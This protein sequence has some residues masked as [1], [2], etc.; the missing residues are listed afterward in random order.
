MSTR[1]MAPTEIPFS[2]LLFDQG[3]VTQAVID[4]PY[5]GS[6]KAD[7]PYVIT[8]IPNDPRNP[9]LLSDSF[10]W[11][12][13]VLVS[14]AALAAALVSSAYSACLVEIIEYF[15]F[16]REVSYVG[17]SL[18]VL[19]FAL[20]PLV[21][22]PL[23]EIYGRRWIYV[24]SMASFT[25]FTAGTAG[26]TNTE[27]LLILR[28][29]AGSMGS[30]GMALPGGVIADIFPATTR[31]LAMGIYATSPFLGPTLGPIIGGFIS[32]SIGW[33]WVEGV[34]AIFT[35]VLVTGIIFLLPETYAPV[36]LQAR[37]QRLEQ[38]TGNSYRSI[39]NSKKPLYKTLGT[40]LS[41]PWLFLF[42]EPI[43]FLLCLYVAIIYGIL[44]LQ[45]AA[46]PIVFQQVRGWSEGI[47]GLS[48]LG[49]LVGILAATAY[50]FPV[51]FQYKR[52]TLA[53]PT[54]R[55]PP[56][57][58]LQSAFVGAIALPIGLF[59][60]AWTNSPSIHWISSIAAGVP[61]GFGMPLVFLP[62]S[63][64]LV[65]TYTIY[66]ASVGAA[67]T[68]LRSTFGAVFPLFTG[69]MFETLGIHWGASV[70]AFLALACAPIPFLF[71]WFGERIRS[72]SKRASEAEEFMQC[73]LGAQQQKKEQKKESG[74]ESV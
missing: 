69:Y 7:D 56:E 50:M 32:E 22:A 16:S 23:S 45:F 33:R 70:P 12:L 38:I 52:K 35:A 65:D 15:H 60:F 3:A 25:A 64:Y 13:T 39:S 48:F 59:W 36:L 4:H 61:F 21:W 41:R 40:A 11:F 53:S 27:S 8:W 31:G 55:L 26:A 58:R 2:G 57:E 63:N 71:Y 34:L 5:P 42:G 43:V 6:G 74:K 46:Y 72:R 14:L 17:I 30:S 18:Y 54:G 19:G 47:G 28:F 9:Q 20:G 10:K 24:A 73:L 44:Y 49:I 1:E 67:N 37:A 68:L 51:Y 29:L 62:V 66:A